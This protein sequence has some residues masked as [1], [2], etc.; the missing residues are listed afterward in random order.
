MIEQTPDAGWSGPW[1]DKAFVNRVLATALTAGE[2]VLAAG[3]GSADAAATM[4]ATALASGLHHVEIDVT[5]T[6]LTISWVPGPDAD[7]TIRSRTV[8][9]RSLDYTR[10][11]RVHRVLGD[12]ALGTV[13]PAAA[14][15]RLDVVRSLDYPYGRR[16][17]EAG[18]AGLAGA[19]VVLLGGGWL[20][21]LLATVSTYGVLVVDR[22]ARGRGLPP[23]FATAA[24]AAGVTAVALVAA[25]L[26]LPL[27]PGLVVSGG[28]V[29][30]LP[31]VALLS[32][33][34]DALAGYVVTAA[35]RFV[36]VFVVLAGIASGVGAA[37]AVSSAF[38]LPLTGVDDE[39]PAAPVLQQLLGGA[40]ASA[41][42]LV[43]VYAPRPLL[44]PAAVIGGLSTAT[45]W[46][47][48]L[49]GTPA[50]FD[51]ALTAVVV[52]TVAVVVAGRL[53]VPS[54]V[55][56]VAG[57]VPLL[58]GLALY[59]GMFRV[60][61]GETTLGI[62]TLTAAVGT[63]FALASGIVL[64]DLAAT[65]LRRLRRLWDRSAHTLVALRDRT[66]R[67]RP[68]GRSLPGRFVGPSVGVARRTG[69]RRRH[70]HRRGDTG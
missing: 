63:V 66:V 68:Y 24:A 14:A 54:L 35:G 20:G 69:Q 2:E 55:L 43:S 50:V 6:S 30:L 7:P 45:A 4:E 18:L 48:A 12:L 28:I 26:G 3:A 51:T 46:L 57:F 56:A 38:G 8:V 32:A 65:R 60:S 5:F 9:Q 52:G 34:Q 62:V 17:A 59:R 39:L 31:S 33:V 1:P 16:T 27:R 42:F 21:V 29:A 11:V 37:L 15:G 44:A 13:S 49:T 25:A 53:N 36:E 40:L 19:V 67:P 41:L 10:L 23:F 58:P 22:A 61:Q 47:L 64:G 70:P